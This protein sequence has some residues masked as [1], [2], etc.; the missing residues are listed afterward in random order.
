[1]KLTQ[2]SVV[3]LEHIKPIPRYLLYAKPRAENQWLLFFNESVTYAQER[4][5]LEDNFRLPENKGHGEIP[6]RTPRL[7]VYL[8]RSSIS[9]IIGGNHHR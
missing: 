5:V 1:M 7:L 2:D 3:A 4:E 8:Q 6:F 9:N